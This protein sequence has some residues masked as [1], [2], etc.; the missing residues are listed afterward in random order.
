MSDPTPCQ[1]SGL[2]NPTA[3]YLSARTRPSL[4]GA[5]TSMCNAEEPLLLSSLWDSLRPHLRW[6]VFLLG[7]VYLPPVQSPCSLGQGSCPVST[8]QSYILRW[9]PKLGHSLTGH[10]LSKQTWLLCSTST[11]FNLAAA[12]VFAAFISEG[13]FLLKTNKHTFKPSPR[14]PL[15]SMPLKT[16]LW[17]SDLLSV[18]DS[19]V[20]FQVLNQTS[21][22]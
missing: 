1:N 14:K 21:T 5:L 18:D 20:L 2:W 22:K 15:V 19:F 13:V 6:K 17:A 3:S 8:T 16:K 12:A 10:S 4:A 11:S 7:S 9:W